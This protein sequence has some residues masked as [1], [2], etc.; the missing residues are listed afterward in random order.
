MGTLIGVLELFILE[1]IQQEEE[2]LLRREVEYTP[3]ICN[4]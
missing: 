2:S 3:K 1:K 4:F